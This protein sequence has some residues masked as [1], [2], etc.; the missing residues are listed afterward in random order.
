[1]LADE[2]VLTRIP[3]NSIYRFWGETQEGTGTSHYRLAKGGL[4]QVGA[5]ET[6]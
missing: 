4:R 6:V 3:G 5:E 1:M 2:R